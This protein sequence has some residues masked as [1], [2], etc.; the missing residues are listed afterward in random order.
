MGWLEQAN[1]LVESHDLNCFRTIGLVPKTTF[2]LPLSRPEVTIS[3][4]IIERAKRA[5][6]LV[7]T[8][9]IFHIC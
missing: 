1:T 9:E 2:L 6:S 7:M 3:V 5:H 8:F 4:Y